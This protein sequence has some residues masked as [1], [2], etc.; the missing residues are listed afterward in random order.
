MESFGP[1]GCNPMW[2]PWQFLQMP[3]MRRSCSPEFV[4]RRG[5]NLLNWLW[6]WTGPLTEKDLKLVVINRPNLKW[7]CINNIIKKC[8]LT[9]GAQGSSQIATT[10]STRA[11]SLPWMVPTQSISWTPWGV[12]RWPL[13]FGA[14]RWCLVGVNLSLLR[15]RKESWQGLPYYHMFGFQVNQVE[16]LASGF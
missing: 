5:S 2:G 10:C 14:N 8:L 15:W 9:L 1:P 3:M 16:L 6:Q 4:T 12:H 7:N 13:F 11:I